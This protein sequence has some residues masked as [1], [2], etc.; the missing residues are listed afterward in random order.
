MLALAALASLLALPVVEAAP[1]ALAGRVIYVVDG[2]TV[3]VQSGDRVEKV[4]Y[5]GVNAPELEH[6]PRPGEAPGR[7][8]PRRL[9]GTPAAAAAA[10]Q[11]NAGLVA[12]MPVRLQLGPRARDDYQRLL[13]YL[14]VGDTLVNAEMIRRGYAEAMTLPPVHPLRDLFVRLEREARDAGRGLWTLAR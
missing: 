14:W 7:R 6:P 8:G 9:P 4:R 11:V 1:P 2:D 13:A 5:L 12:G 10:R 3:H